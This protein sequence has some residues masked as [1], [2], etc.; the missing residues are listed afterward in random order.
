MYNSIIICIIIFKANI[1][2]LWIKQNKSWNK[3]PTWCLGVG[4]RGCE[5]L[6][7]WQFIY[8]FFY[9]FLFCSL[10]DKID[11]VCDIYDY[12]ISFVAL[13]KLPIIYLLT[14]VHRRLYS[15]LNEEMLIFAL[16]VDLIYI[17][18]KRNPYMSVCI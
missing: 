18:H 7:Y 16:T 17:T 9:F 8:R 6:W 4:Q 13:I 5:I 3:F 12:R 15:L 14:N 2:Y 1:F 10:L 11:I